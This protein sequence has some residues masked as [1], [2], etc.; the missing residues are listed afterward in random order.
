MSRLPRAARLGISLTV[1][2]AVIALLLFVVFP[3]GQNTAV[4][5]ATSK[6]RADTGTV[7]VLVSQRWGGG[8]L[9]LV[10]FDRAGKRMLRL[11]Y[12]AHGTRGWRATGTTT[13]RADITDVAVGS[14]LVARSSGGSGQPAWSV[15]A[16]ELG[17]PRIEAIQVKW[18]TGQ[19][20]TGRRENDS[21]LVIER[22]T[23]QVASVRF[24]SKDGSEIATVPVG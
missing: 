6:L 24:T 19:T 18:T 16:G 13:Q 5:A 23:M 9:V 12:A 14:L 22:G 11:V 2:V 3:S 8:E 15:A 21:Y 7:R 10:R 4:A 17:D 20:T 1:L